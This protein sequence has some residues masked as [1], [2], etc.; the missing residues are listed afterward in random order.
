MK[1]L[2]LTNF[3]ATKMELL[4]YCGGGSLNVYVTTY[5]YV[6][7]VYTVRR[8]GVKKNPKKCLCSLWMPPDFVVTKIDE[9]SKLM[10]SHFSMFGLGQ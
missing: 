5:A 2:I 1:N 6:V 10:N 8:G 3:N 4:A 9:S 7:K